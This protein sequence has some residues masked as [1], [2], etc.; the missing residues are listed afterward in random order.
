LVVTAKEREEALFVTS[1][2]GRD[3]LSFAVFNKYHCCLLQ[4]DLFVVTA[5]ERAEALFVTSFEGGDKLC[6]A[7]L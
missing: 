2:E 1:F 3:K 5:K 6:F 4:T 7:M